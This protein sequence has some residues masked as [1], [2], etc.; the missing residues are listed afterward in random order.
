MTLISCDH[1]N[2]PEG[3]TST[4]TT[5]PGEG[6]EGQTQVVHSDEYNDDIVYRTDTSEWHVKVFKSGVLSSENYA[7]YVK[8]PYRLP[9][10]D[11]GKILKNITY[12]QS[13][14]R[15][16]TDDGYTFGMPSAGVSK[17]GTKKTYSVLGMWIRTTVYKYEF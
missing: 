17:A 6:S 14:E 9:T 16:F 2:D 15:Y 7:S 5:N 8:S 10:R 13:G 3:P 1:T 11:E 12:G 4:E